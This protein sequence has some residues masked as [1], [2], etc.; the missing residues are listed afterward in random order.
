MN[1]YNYIAT[2][3]S[4]GANDLLVNYGFKP[5]SNLNTLIERLKII[6]RKYK[7]IA[8]KDLTLIH[9]DKN[10]LEMFTTSTFDDKDFA[11]ATG[12]TPGFVEP[13]VEEP[14]SFPKETPEP[15]DNSAQNALDT[16]KVVEEIK[17]VKKQ[18]VK[19]KLNSERRERNNRLLS[20]SSSSNNQQQY[21]MLA[22]GL[23]VGYIIGKK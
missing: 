3:N 16:A 11:Y 8:L 18:M 1:I 15:F 22:V 14:S 17:S 10:L 7:K 13:V 23:I 2:N 20:M 4:E 9:P 19:E 21:L 12:R 5:T 6:V